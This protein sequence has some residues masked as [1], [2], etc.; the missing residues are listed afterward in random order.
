MTRTR[1]LP[2]RS[3][4]LVVLA[5][6]A[7]AYSNSFDCPFNFD[8]EAAII[9]NQSLRNWADGWPVLFDIPDGGATVQGRP[10]LN[11]SFALNYAI[12]EFDV[13]G[14]HVTNVA[15]HA[16][17]ALALF[18]LVRRTLSLPTVSPPL[19]DRAT[20]VAVATALVWAAHPLQT[21]SVTYIVQRA[22]SLAGLWYL[23]TAYAFAR[24]ATARRGWP[25]YVVS[26]VCCGLGM[27]TKE[28]VVSAPLAVLLYDRA[29]LSGSFR[30]ALR[31]RPGVYA[32]LASTWL[33][34]GSLVLG[35]GGR[36][37]TA[38]F[39]SG[40]SALD[41]ALSQPVF[42]LRYLRLTVWPDPL[43]FDY[44][45]ELVTDPAVY[46]PAAVVVAGLATVALWAVLRRPRA[47][48]LGFLFFALLAPT[49]SF[50][51][52]AT[53]TAAEHRMY[54][55]LAPLAVLVVTGS[56]VAAD[57]F[58]RAGGAVAV[59]GWVMLSAVLAGAT[60]ARNL[61][62]QSDLGMW[63]DVVAK[64]PGNARA[65]F[66]VGHLASAAGDVDR[67][68]REYRAALAGGNVGEVT[69]SGGRDF[70]LYEAKIR[71]LTGRRGLALAG[72]T[73][74]IVQHP[75]DPVVYAERGQLRLEMG[76]VSG[77]VKDYSEAVRLKPDE[78]DYRA[79]LAAAA[80]RLG[81]APGAAGPGTP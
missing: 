74:V 48:L 4:G 26:V 5:V 42:I 44:G 34:L 41:Y 71:R 1:L 39:E 54:L 40:V 49:S 62:Y 68:E 6:V 57:R 69:A 21:E 15:I 78:P 11:A 37:G 25:W 52:V 20:G 24:G 46:V 29:F 67:G 66:N 18:G 80:G 16:L 36:G 47:G 28:V 72:Y 38:G 79:G 23:L 43:V 59:G 75:T 51:P 10:V 33:I 70:A 7:V 76:D 13:R 65:H 3:A 77:A 64:Q 45:V 63:E 56:V 81:N 12:G 73:L 60:Y 55:P 58:G 30:A 53:Q 31:A 50:V 22:E 32:A 27:G 8:D 14:Y 2:G 61:D 9:N 35:A 19:S 17:A